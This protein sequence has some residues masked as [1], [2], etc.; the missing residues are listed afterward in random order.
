MAKKIL[1]RLPNWL[2]DM[3]MS[4]A[5]LQALGQQ[6]PGAQVGVIVKKG[7]EGLVPFL[8][9]VSQH[10]VFN[11][12]NYRGLWGAVRFGKTLEQ[13]GFDLFFCLPN[14][15]SSAAMAWGTG[16][17]QR[18]GFDVEWRG[19]LLTHTYK[20][21]VAKHRLEQYVHLLKRFTKTDLAIPAP[22]LCT[23]AVVRPQHLVINFNSEAVSR[24][25]PVEK[26]QAILQQLLRQTSAT[27]E[28]VGGPADADH[29]QQIQ[30]GIGLEEPRL[31]NTAGKTTLPQLVATLAGAAAVLSTDSGPAHL[32]NALG[33]PLV[34]LFGAG[35]E[36]QTAPYEKKALTVLR[37]AQL[38]CEPCIRNTCQF[39]MPKCLQLLSE[40]EIVAAVR[41]YL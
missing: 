33:R 27:I 6:Y 4:T 18:M 12:A 41:Q 29:V 2:G 9:G 8:P 11:K 22:R 7:L 36:R 1:V 23:S 19:I 28:L 32:A 17:R 15:L 20:L 3:V 21:P 13:Q 31:T 16:A 40:V 24:R 37:L 35:N 14:S 34:V 26:A 30:A 39:G 5:F 38:P 25:M 10:F